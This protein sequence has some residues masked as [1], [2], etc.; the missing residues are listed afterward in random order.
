MT[1]VNHI[2]KREVVA[3]NLLYLLY[4]NGIYQDINYTCMCELNQ[5]LDCSDTTGPSM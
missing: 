3:N 1:T 4:Y 2:E 5:R